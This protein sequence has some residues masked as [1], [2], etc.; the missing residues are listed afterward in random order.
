MGAFWGALG[1]ALGSLLGA[2][3]ASLGHLW[4]PLGPPGGT[5]WDAGA[6]WGHVL[7][8]LGPFLGPRVSQ[9]GVRGSFSEPG[10]DICSRFG[11]D[12]GQYEGASAKIGEI[13]VILIFAVDL[14]EM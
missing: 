6:P 11:G 5:L 4:A 14:D 3:W 2:L 12:V 10:G 7:G 9:R 1:E 8:H 13:V